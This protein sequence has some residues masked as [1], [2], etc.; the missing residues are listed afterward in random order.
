MTVQ[1]RRNTDFQLRMCRGCLL[2]EARQIPLQMESERQEIR[3]DNNTTDASGSKTRHSAIEVGRAEFEKCGF[4]VIESA[5]PRQL[6]S[7][8]PHRFIGR[9]DAGTVRKHDESGGHTAPWM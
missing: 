5:G 7:S 6:S 1:W 4:H 3:Q 9:F 2:D 8:F